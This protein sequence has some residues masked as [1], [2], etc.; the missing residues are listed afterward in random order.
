MISLSFYGAA[1]MVTGSKY[2]VTVNDQRVL[3][4]C[5]MF[6]GRKELRKLNWEPPA[7]KPES[8]AGVILTHGHIDHIGYL[9][10]LVRFGYRGPVFA[11][12]PTV[13]I[14]KLSLL[15]AAHIQ[16][17]D[18]EYRNKKKLT[19]HEKALPLF[20]DEDVAAIDAMYQAAPFD[21]W[22]E[23]TDR[24]RFRL[25]PAGHILGAASVELELTDDDRKV[26]VLFS[27]DVGRYGNPL[28]RNP[29]EPPSTDYLVCE[30]TYGGRIHPPEDAHQDFIDLIREAV[31]RKSVLLI[32]AFAIGR[33][34]QVTF[35]IDRL[36]EHGLVPDID[37]HIDSPMAISATDI[38]CKYASLHSID[39]QKLGGKNCVLHGKRVHLHR[40]RKSSKLLNKMKGPAVILSSSGMLTGGRIMHHLINRLP[41]PRTT[42][43]LVGFMAEGTTGRRL[44]DGADRIYIHKQPVEVKA[45]VKTLHG[46]SGHADY[47]EL[48]HWA[49]NIT[50]APKRVFVTHGEASQAAAMA[51]H[52]RTERGWD[53]HIPALEETVTL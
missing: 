8:V 35:L 43:A 13:D 38:Y 11:T 46:L 16:M 31:E 28:T 26:S 17:E 6:Q 48:L 15:D 41:D 22:T 27:G 10:R 50:P 42:V 19:S 49:E 25:H 18:A 4:D 52:F 9:P 51:G 3:V 24:I 12:H 1:G 14:A 33:T 39:L 20:D 32:P 5:G 45:R 29:G 53:C 23:V 47:Y 7:F 30:S 36:I 40:K 34:Q 44:V 21:T 2:L 37:I